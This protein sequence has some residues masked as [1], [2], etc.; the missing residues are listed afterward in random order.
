MSL[1]KRIVELPGQCQIRIH[2]CPNALLIERAY[3]FRFHSQIKIQAG[4]I[5]DSSAGGDCAA[6]YGSTKLRDIEP[7]TR[8]GEHAIAVPETKWNSGL[9]KTRVDD[10]NLPL[11]IRIRARAERIDVKTELAGAGRI[12]AEHLRQ[13]QINRAAQQ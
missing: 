5:D 11:N 2:G 13:A 8:Q 1:E 3:S 9:R 7:V 10:S 6:S 4:T 12:R